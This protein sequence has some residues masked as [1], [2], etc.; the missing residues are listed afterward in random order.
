MAGEMIGA[1]GEIPRKAN[2]SHQPS[3]SSNIILWVRIS[4][5][6]LSSSIRLS[7]RIWTRATGTLC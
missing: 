3:S 2:Q 5:S 1:I 4:T 7:K 6:N